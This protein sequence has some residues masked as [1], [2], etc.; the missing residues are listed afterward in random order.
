MH[1]IRDGR[2]P[3]TD[4]AKALKKE[5]ERIQNN[6]GPIWHYTQGGMYYQQVKRYL[7]AFERTQI[8]IYLYDEFNAEPVTVLTDIFQFLDVTDDWLPDM[9]VRHNVSGVPKSRRFQE[10]LHTLL[11]KPN[12]VKTISRLVIP[13]QVRWRAT[14]AV[15]NLNLIRSSL[16]PEMRHRLTEEQFREDIL[17]LQDLLARDLS[18]WL[19]SS[20]D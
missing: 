2:E 12:P 13:E 5:H 4:F 20:V 19:A 18:H 11:L 17:K 1:L 15:R 14:T 9:S 16:S 10:F 8:K 3:I 7:D 6:W